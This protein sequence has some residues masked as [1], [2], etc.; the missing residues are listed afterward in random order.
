MRYVLFLVYFFVCCTSIQAQQ[1]E[2]RE[3][4][5]H[6]QKVPKA[7]HQDISGLTNYLIKPAKSE[8]EKVRAI[9]SWITHNIDYDVAAY[10]NG[11]KRINKN[12]RD[13][14]D[15]RKA[16]CF[17][18]ATLFR[19]MCKRAN[20]KAALISGYSKG[21]LTAQ[22]K[23]DRPD[24]AWNAVLIEQKWYVLDATWGSSLIDKTNDFVQTYKEGYFLTSPAFFIINHLPADPMW[25]LLDCPIPSNLFLESADSIL[26]YT[27]TVE[28]CF[29]YQDSIAQFFALNYP[30]QRLK[31]AQNTHGY[32]PTPDNQKAL[33]HAYMDLAGRLSDRA[34]QF[35]EAEQF[36]AMVEV[37]DS[38]INY[39]RKARAHA[40]LYHWQ[41]ELFINTL[42]NQATAKSKLADQFTE[43]ASILEQ[44]D[45]ILNLLK[46]S[47]ALLEAL[48]D[49]PFKA[50]AKE[51]TDSYIEIAEYN[52]NF[53]K[54][55]N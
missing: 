22:P 52:L 41:N 46:E 51:A 30:Q 21:T 55:R 53:H 35:Q 13:I 45:Q 33:G 54:T 27:K 18:Y 25:Q 31:E 4:D 14:L 19:E 36:Q 9:Y 6:A 32:H 1:K 50:Y 42:I 7:L 2:F 38:V 10:K 5:R 37:Q 28:P 15:R 8:L 3:I 12:N 24:H 40:A 16:V 39:C 49:S 34:E 26:S 48:P 20:I 47:Q 44:Y 29:S 11:N 43:K 17:G 23:L